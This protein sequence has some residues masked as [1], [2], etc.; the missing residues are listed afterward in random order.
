[1]MKAYDCIEWQ[2]LHG[3]LIKLGFA[4]SWVNSLM[5][6][7]TSARYAVR[8]NGELSSP[9]V[10]SRGIRQ[11][12]PIGPYL[13]LLCTECL[14]CLLQKKECLGELQGLR[15]GRQ[16]PSISHLL[17]ADDSIFFAHS[18]NKSVE[19]LK[20]ALDMYC[21]ASGQR[22]NLTKSSVF[23]GNSCNDAIKI[24]VKAQLGV[25]NEIL[26]DSYLGM[27]TEVATAVTSS[28][29]FFSDKV[30]KCVNT[31][32][33]R[34]LSRAGKESLLKSV[35]QSIPNYVMSCFQVPVAI[36][37]KMRSEPLVGF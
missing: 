18:D 36:C 33:G 11:G 19:A 24:R 37:D 34:A 28:F 2:Y 26:K 6:C 5:R 13:F 12:D 14:S 15:N 4:P 22:I 35:V 21:E 20:T 31:C 7:V 3:C 17:F 16:G 23:F 8:V 27:P 30:W 32:S 25:D 10:P 9:V 1:M 29:K